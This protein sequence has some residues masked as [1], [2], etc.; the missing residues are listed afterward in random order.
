MDYI[1]KRALFW[2]YNG[3]FGGKNGDIG[4]YDFG[5]WIG[6]FGFKG[7]SLRR[8]ALGLVIADFGL[9]VITAFRVWSLIFCIR[10]G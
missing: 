9:K 6:D 2:G 5:F 1:Q 7:K 8:T 4:P 3:L 10:L